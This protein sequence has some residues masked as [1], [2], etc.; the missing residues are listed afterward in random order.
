M[1]SRVASQLIEAVDGVG[2]TLYSD[3]KS[4]V[5]NS[6]NVV[7]TSDRVPVSASASS[8]TVES[9]GTTPPAITLTGT[10]NRFVKLKVVCTTL[11]ARG[12]AVVKYSTDGGDT[13]I[14]NVTTAASWTVKDTA[15]AVEGVYEET[16]LTI[17]YANASAAVDNY[18]ITTGN[19][20]VSTVLLG[21][22]AVGIWY[23]ASRAGMQTYHD[24]LKNADMLAHHVYYVPV[25][26]NHMIGNVKRPMVSVL[27]TKVVY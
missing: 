23:S 7:E 1:H 27:K 14:E 22:R 5:G 11:G 18:W 12:T 24:V 15:S 16:G 9:F 21:K 10:A 13:W 2:R 6:L 17:N 4:V 26:R 19:H 25:R 8:Y 20:T 3:L